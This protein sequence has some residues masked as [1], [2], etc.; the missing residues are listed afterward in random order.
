MHLDEGKIRQSRLV[1]RCRWTSACVA[2]REG[3][4]TRSEVSFICHLL[5]IRRN[6][7]S[8]SPSTF[9]PRP[10]GPFILM[11]DFAQGLDASKL[12]LVEAVRSHLYDSRDHC[13][14]LALIGTLLR[15]QPIQRP[16]VQPARFSFWIICSRE[17]GSLP[18]FASSC[19]LASFTDDVHL[20]AFMNSTAVL[21]FLG[22]LRSIRYH[23]AYSK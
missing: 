20:Q 14:S 3:G 19:K 22:S 6:P 11:A 21:R 7:L 5:L 13:N 8:L 10:A 15:R 17:S 18:S 2:G 1:R 9:D 4:P 23:L 16:Y 12:I